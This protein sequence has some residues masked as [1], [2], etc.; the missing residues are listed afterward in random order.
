METGLLVHLFVLLFATL[1]VVGGLLFLLIDM[2]S[3]VDYLRKEVP[4]LEKIG[5]KRGVIRGLLIVAIFLLLGNGYELVNK[6]VPE[7]GVI[8]AKIPTPIAPAVTVQKITIKTTGSGRLDRD[9]NE[10]QSD[11]LYRQL[12]GYVDAPNKIAP[13]SV[14]LVNAIP[15][16]GSHSIYLHD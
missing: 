8:Q 6:E 15:V 13:A 1:A 7:P 16:I 2:L 12:K 3:R 10:Q 5:E 4:W 11:H 14:L 9:F